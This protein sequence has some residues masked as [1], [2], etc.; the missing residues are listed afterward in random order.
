M[1]KTVWGIALGAAL[2]ASSAVAKVSSVEDYVKAGQPM[3][4]VLNQ[5]LESGMT[6]KQA[7]VASVAAAPQQKDE[8]VVAAVALEPENAQAHTQLA[9]MA[10]GAAMLSQ[11]LNSVEDYVKAGYPMDQVLD[12]AMQDGMSLDQA[13]V[14]TLV[15]APQQADAIISAAVAKEPQRAQEIVELAAAAGVD[16]EQAMAAALAGGADPSSIS[17][18]TAA[19]RA[20]ASRGAPA[21]LPAP[22]WSN[23]GGVGNG[24]PG[25]SCASAN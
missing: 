16:S 6:M 3:D 8:L 2:M 1:D 19:G 7:I 11:D 14:E 13:F 25:N 20:L 22:P 9:A 23:A 4:Q 10:L 12:N 18:P 24:C 5:A 21:N 15:A 17:A